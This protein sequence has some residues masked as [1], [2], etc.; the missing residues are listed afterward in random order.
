MKKMLLIQ[1]A[2]IGDVVLA[3]ALLEKIKLTHPEIKLHILVRKGNES[4][5]DN[6]PYIEKVWIWNKK[7]SKYRNLF[8]LLFQIRNEKFDAVINVQRYAATAFLTVL[9]G[10]KETV[11]FNT[12]ILSKFYTIAIQHQFNNTDRPLHEIERNQQL[13]AHFTGNEPAMPKL[14]YN[15]T[16]LASIQHLIQPPYICVA[17]A[18]VWFTKQFPEEKWVEFLQKIPDDLLV[19]FLGGPSDFDLCS[20][21]ALQL[22]SKHV[23]NLAGQ[24]SFLQSAALM[25]HAVMNYVNDSAPMHFASAVNAPV[26]AI[27]CSTIPNFGYGPLSTE[28]YIIQV[29][30]KLNCRPCGLHGKKACPQKHFHCALHIQPE[31]LLQPLLQ[32][33]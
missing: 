32:K 4:L 30:E 31:Q 1:T 8:K 28:K 23:V 11:G 13:I 9:S 15:Q 2:F 27:F 20:Q 5:F 14:Y 6:H 33:L 26:A 12:H 7:Q 18:S 22:A 21:I 10:A 16:V 3:T 17:P 25:Q 19:Y 29:N 24:I